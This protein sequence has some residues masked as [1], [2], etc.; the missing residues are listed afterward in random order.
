MIFV[1]K[2]EPNNCPY[3]TMISSMCWPTLWPNQVLEFGKQ[4]SF[5][6]TF[7]SSLLILKD[8]Y[9]LNSCYWYKS[10]LSKEKIVISLLKW[11]YIL[12]PI[13]YIFIL[14]VL[15]GYLFQSNYPFSIC[16]CFSPNI[17]Y[18]RNTAVFNFS[19]VA[20]AFWGWGAGTNPT[21][22]QHQTE[23]FQPFKLLKHDALK[24]ISFLINSFFLYAL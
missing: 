19:V 21:V 20:N 16:K 24:I 2:N 7:I 10:S 17:S 12:N 6:L 5:R 9:P 1:I 4:L 22:F 8:S 13:L 3:D 11:S 18:F 15:K 14:R 23:I